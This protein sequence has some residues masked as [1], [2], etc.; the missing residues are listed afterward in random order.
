M[1]FITQ[2]KLPRRTL[3][4]SA[5]V[6]VGLP[7]LDAMVPAFAQSAPTPPKRFV[8][9]WHPHGV[10]PGYWSPTTARMAAAAIGV[11]RRERKVRAPQDQ[12]AG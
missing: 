12:D 8:G 5:G 11:I 6:S 7:L 1:K 3:I 2:K 10:A 4:K 9:V